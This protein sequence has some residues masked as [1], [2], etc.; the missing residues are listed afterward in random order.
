MFFVA[1]LRPLFFTF[2]RWSLGNS[3]TTVVNRNSS[4]PPFFSTEFKMFCFLSLELIKT[5]QTARKMSVDIL[6]F[7]LLSRPVFGIF[8]HTSSALMVFWLLFFF[9]GLFYWDIFLLCYGHTPFLFLHFFSYSVCVSYDPQLTDVWP[10]L[11]V[12]SSLLLLGF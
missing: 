6:C 4:K 1:I 7:L 3:I 8:F 2:S 11:R 12:S 5:S 10:V 9:F